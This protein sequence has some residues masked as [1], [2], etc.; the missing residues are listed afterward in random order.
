MRR[1]IQGG[2]GSTTGVHRTIAAKRIKLGFFD[3]SGHSRRNFEEKSE[4]NRIR[5]WN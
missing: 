1:R 5:R 4:K 3:E 2:L